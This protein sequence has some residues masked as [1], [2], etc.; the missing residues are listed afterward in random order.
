MR[1]IEHELKRLRDVLIKLRGEETKLKENM[2]DGGR[3]MQLS[4]E[5]RKLRQE[6]RKLWAQQAKLRLQR[7][8]FYLE[9]GFPLGAGEEGPQVPNRA[10]TV[11]GCDNAGAAANVNGSCNGGR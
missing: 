10:E 4:E 5:Q 8:E 6:Q 7:K 1:N 2:E 11:Q 9:H 3:L